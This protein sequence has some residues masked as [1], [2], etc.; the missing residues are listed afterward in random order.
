V[1][2]DIVDHIIHGEGGHLV[3]KFLDRRFGPAS[4]EWAMRVKWFGIDELEASWE[5]ARIMLEDQPRLVEQF[6][7]DRGSEP[8]VQLMATSLGVSANEPDG[9]QS[10][11]RQRRRAEPKVPR[12]R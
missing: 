12:G 4:H 2:E 3:E 7:A 6:I 9:G 8:N 10:G 5:P 11:R 1:T